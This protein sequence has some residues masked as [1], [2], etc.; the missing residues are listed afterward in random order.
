MILHLNVACDGYT[1][2]H[3]VAFVGDRQEPSYCGFATAGAEIGRPAYIVASRRP[4]R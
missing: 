1:L 2:R 4:R 3:A